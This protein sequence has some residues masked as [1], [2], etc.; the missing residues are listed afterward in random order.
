M[1]DGSNALL[2]LERGVLDGAGQA[3]AAKGRVLHLILER[4]ISAL[5][6]GRCSVTGRSTSFHSAGGARLLNLIFDPDKTEGGGTFND[7]SSGK[8]ER[9]W[10][11]TEEDYLLQ[12]QAQI[13]N[14]L[15]KTSV[16]YTTTWV[17]ETLLVDLPVEVSDDYG[18]QCPPSNSEENCTRVYVQS[19]GKKRGAC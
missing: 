11:L 10:L 8:Y 4:A 5:G 9:E 3:A 6:G 16:D 1:P 14:N 12:F 15:A 2:N 18:V 13:S 17:N 7:G 19:W